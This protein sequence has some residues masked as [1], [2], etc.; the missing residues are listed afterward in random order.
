[1]VADNPTTVPREVIDLKQDVIGISAAQWGPHHA[2]LANGSVSKWWW[3]DPSTDGGSVHVA[4][5]NV[6][7]TARQVVSGV[8]HACAL[9]SDGGVSCWGS[10]SFG[11]L[12]RG[13]AADAHGEFSPARVILP[14]QAL[15][16]AAG[17]F[18]TCALLVG[19][20]VECW[21]FNAWGELGVGDWNSRDRPS[22]VT[23]ASPATL[24][25]AGADH[26]CVV[27]ASG[28]VQCWG[29]NHDGELG[30]GSTVEHASPVTAIGAP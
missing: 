27:L 28:E 21:G 17:E 22:S 2:I 1:M 11:E 25:A 29:A 8:S 4:N 15:A 9:L 3:N 26:T 23:L 30:D 5:I 20:L 13:L 12:G 16:L 7:G 19:G 18:H 6:D 10:N 24:L 14:R